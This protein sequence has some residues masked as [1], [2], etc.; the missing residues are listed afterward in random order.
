MAV[1]KSDTKTA[2]F[3]EILSALKLGI[4]PHEKHLTVIY[5]NDKGY[6]LNA[7]YS[8]K[9]NRDIFFA[10]VEIKKNYVS[11]HLFP[12]YM[13]PVLLEDIS[14]ELKKRMQGKACF[15]FKS[16][17]KK[18]FAELK[19]LTKTGFQTMKQNGFIAKK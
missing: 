4:K 14:P 18:L 5:D 2:D 12:V 16:P 11:Y 13:F 9:Y 10:A 1:N 8:D 15:N 6:Y 7:A 3:S 17:D 19:S